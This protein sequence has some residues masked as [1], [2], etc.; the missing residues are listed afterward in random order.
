[1]AES[2]GIGGGRPPEPQAA[3]ETGLRAPD[4]ESKIEFLISAEHRIVLLSCPE[5]L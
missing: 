5:V 1:M 3:H 4:T 2:S